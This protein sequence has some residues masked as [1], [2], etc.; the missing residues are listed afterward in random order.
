LIRHH[1]VITAEV[2]KLIMQLIHQI[3][4]KSLFCQLT[5]HVDYHVDGHMVIR[6]TT[7]IWDAEKGRCLRF[8]KVRLADVFAV[9]SDALL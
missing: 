1:E 6:A 2:S 3:I 5:H 7:Q 4:I 9:N 8:S